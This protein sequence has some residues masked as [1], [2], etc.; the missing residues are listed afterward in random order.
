M[1][2]RI[3]MEH[4]RL[5]RPAAKRRKNTAT[6]KW[7]NLENTA[8][9]RQKSAAHGAS[10]GEEYEEQTSPSGAKERCNEASDLLLGGA[11]AIQAKRKDRL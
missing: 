5:A 6:V 9:K 2:K 10:R 11:V 7:R 8:A 4:G 3:S 1:T